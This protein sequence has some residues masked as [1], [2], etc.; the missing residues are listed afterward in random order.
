MSEFTFWFLSFFWGY[1]MTLIGLITL[2]ILKH[3]G[4]EPKK[5]NYAYMFEIGQYWG[6]ITLGPVII[7]NRNP[8]QHLKDHEFGHCLQN[9]YFGPYMVWVGILSFIR[10]W[11]REFIQ[12]DFN[13]LPVFLKPVRKLFKNY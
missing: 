7:V 12:K 3:M 4:Y 10:Y 13:E 8:S 1:W 5:Y 9:C 2:F 11:F 6:G